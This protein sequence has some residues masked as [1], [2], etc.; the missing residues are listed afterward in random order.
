ML[1]V[2]SAIRLRYAESFTDCETS[3]LR[4]VGGDDS[5]VGSFRDLRSLSTV[6]IEVPVD[7][8]LAVGGSRACVIEV[9]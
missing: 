6:P 2:K 4:A 3:G 8:P 5:F 9:L 1:C 7:A